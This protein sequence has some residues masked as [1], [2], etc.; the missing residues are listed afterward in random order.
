MTA[1]YNSTELG[2]AQFRDASD[3]DRPLP[4]ASGVASEITD[5]STDNLMIVRT[6]ILVSDKDKE[7]LYNLKAALSPFREINN[8][9][10]E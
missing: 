10:I 4:P 9:L 8:D 2:A 7:L 6:L 3:S 1:E 5:R